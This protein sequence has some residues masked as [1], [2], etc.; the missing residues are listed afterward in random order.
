ML[1]RNFS[2][3]LISLFV[4][5]MLLTICLMYVS[6]A[7]AATYYIN[8]QVTCSDANAGTSTSAPW[9]NISHVTGITFAAGDSI[10]LARGATWTSQVMRFTNSGTSSSYI[11]LDAYGSGN[12]PIITGTGLATDRAVVLTNVSYWNIRNLEISRVAA[13][14]LFEY[15][16]LTHEGINISNIYVHHVNGI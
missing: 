12:K 2:Y 5:L 14:I 13:G 16:T 11:T 8:N 6:K 7:S 10:L 15:T 4:F 1:I 3:R 9:C